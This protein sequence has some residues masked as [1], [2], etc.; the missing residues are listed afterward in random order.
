MSSHLASPFLL[1]IACLTCGAKEAKPTPA[2]HARPAVPAAT[3][4]PSVHDVK[5]DTPAPRTLAPLPTPWRALPGRRD[6][7][8]LGPLRDNGAFIAGGSEQRWLLQLG[9]DGSQKLLELGAG[10]LVAAAGTA[11]GELLLAGATPSFKPWFGRVDARGVLAAQA[12]Y[13]PEISGNWQDIIPHGEGALLVGIHS[14]LASEFIQGWALFV[15][16][17]GEVIRDHRLGE[18]SFHLLL[19]GLSLPDGGALVFG[20]KKR[21]TY[22]PW[23]VRI[24]AAG[25]VA[26]EQLRASD[27]WGGLDIATRTADG[28]VYTASINA[29]QAHTLPQGRVEVL[30]ADSEGVALWS[31]LWLDA[32]VYIGSMTPLP[33]G[34]AMFLAATRTNPG[35]ELADAE[36]DLLL[37]RVPPD[38]S[39]P[40]VSVIEREVVMLH[41]QNRAAG[42]IVG[43]RGQDIVILQLRRQ[44]GREDEYEW[45]FSAVPR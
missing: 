16:R 23:L 4:E 22:L 43:L 15:G 12:V 19:S 35:S 20:A 6:I 37:V 10:R 32:V 13:A 8:D 28:S 42:A 40:I 2:G 39:E 7:H 18:G 38:G 34:G 21:G 9:A 5:V 3:A 45:R 25:A 14:P 1:S 41:F 44:A 30:K 31:H 11:S 33:E 27:P 17:D 29:E 36:G 24:D 26:S